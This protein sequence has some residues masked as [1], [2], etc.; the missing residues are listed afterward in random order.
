MNLREAFGD[1]DIYLFDQLLKG[2]INPSMK[3]LD[4]GCG[5]GRNLI[6]FLRN[7]YQVSAVDADH[8]AVHYVRELATHIAPALAKENF[9][10]A[11][12]AELPFADQQFDL[13]ISS[14][15]LHFA[16]DESHFNRMLD[17]MWRVLKPGGMFFARLASSIGIESDVRQIDGRWFWL[18]DGTERFL[19]DE[20]MLQSASQRLKGKWLEPLKTTNVENQRCM[21]TWILEKL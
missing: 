20:A 13:V 19:V 15:V 6:Y 7:G 21:T 14:A 16:K 9:L 8:R 17:E 1:I 11:E 5:N 4:A 18:P 3:L 10:A 2:R 12:V